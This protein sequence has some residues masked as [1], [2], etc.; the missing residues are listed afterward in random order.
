MIILKKRNHG[1]FQVYNC[2]EIIIILTNI[3][4]KFIASFLNYNLMNHVVHLKLGLY[5]FKKLVK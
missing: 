2:Y 5:F 1:C 3:F 4:F